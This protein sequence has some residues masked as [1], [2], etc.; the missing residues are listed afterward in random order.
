VV[1]VTNFEHPFLIAISTSVTPMGVFFGIIFFLGVWFWLQQDIYNDHKGR[2]DKLIYLSD[3]S[4][5]ILRQF[6]WFVSLLL[7]GL[8]LSYFLL[9]ATCYR[10]YGLGALLQ[11]EY[12][13]AVLKEFSYLL[14]GLFVTV[15]FVNLVLSFLEGKTFKYSQFLY[16]VGIVLIF[17]VFAVFIL[18]G[19]FTL[20][21]VLSYYGIINYAI[22]N[23][24]LYRGDLE[25]VKPL[26]MKAVE[27]GPPNPPSTPVQLQPNQLGTIIVDEQTGDI[28]AC[29]DMKKTLDMCTE[30][31]K[32]G[33]RKGWAESYGAKQG[34]GIVK[35]HMGVP[36]M[37]CA[38]VGHFEPERVKSVIDAAR[39][40]K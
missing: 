39:K 12:L 5:S 4:V 29:I 20:N 37:V 28:N 30:N 13:L 25:R 31:M 24:P 7:L 21:T 27:T 18:P 15:L 34:A 33:T 36:D 10:N 17:M 1:F 23:E 14:L 35:R 16:D 2:A 6:R 9:K 11:M 19:F 40:D 22:D 32:D 38:K 8:T 26:L 3:I